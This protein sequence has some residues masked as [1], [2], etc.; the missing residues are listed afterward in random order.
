MAEAIN[1]SWTHWFEIP[2]SN[3]YRA[4]TFYKTIYNM[5]ID[6]F[7]AG[8]LKMGISPHNRAGGGVLQTKKPISEEHCFMAFFLDSEG[9]QIPL[10]SMT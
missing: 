2:V 1:R 5:K 6:Y 10:N 3:F 8:V 7:E 4:I 9:N